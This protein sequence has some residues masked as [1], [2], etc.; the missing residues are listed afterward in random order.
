MRRISFT[1]FTTSSLVPILLFAAAVTFA[2]RR[3]RYGGTLTID[4]QGRV[5][6]LDPAQKQGSVADQV[7][8][9]RLLRLIA[10]RLVTLDQ[11]GQPKPEL[12]I[13]WQHD[14]KFMR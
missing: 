3:P 11:F 7:A 14:D 8:Q 13:S 10:D 9:G 5:T 4:L 6:S 2:A 12:A 1:R